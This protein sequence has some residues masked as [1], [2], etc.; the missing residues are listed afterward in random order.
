MVNPRA[1]FDAPV[2]QIQ[3]R[4]ADCGPYRRDS[5]AKPPTTSGCTE[6]WAVHPVIYSA[7]RESGKRRFLTALGKGENENPFM[8]IV[9]FVVSQFL[10]G[11]WVWA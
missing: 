4:C 8:E 5:P 3:F 6:N 10:V 9:G 7:R 2:M 1:Q 11:C